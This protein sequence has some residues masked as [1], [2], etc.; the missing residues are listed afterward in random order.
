[1]SQNMNAP[2]IAVIISVYNGLDDLRM[3]LASLELQTFKNFEIVIAD[4]GSS[5]D[6]VKEMDSI[7]SSSPLVIRHIWHEDRG[8]RKNIIL[9]RA[10]VASRGQYLVFIDGDCILHPCLLH[11]HFDHREP[12]YLIAGRRVNL[13]PGITSRLD[14]QKVSGGVLW[15]KYMFRIIFGGLTGKTKHFEN[16]IYVKSPRLRNRIN[17]KEKHILGSHFSI[18]KEDI[19]AV[20]GFDERFTAPAAGEDT[21]LNLRLSRNGIRTKTLKHIAIQYHLY[22]QKLYRDPE[23]LKILEQNTKEN[24]NYTPYG[25]AREK[26][27]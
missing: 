8:W 4:D 15:G 2:E 21:D 20:N 26:T 12:G 19:L 7:I 22:H 10:I 11:E 9:N 14:P 25:I 5:E 24:I 16:A 13:S 18:H 23:R 27:D 3:V 6:V 1:M 17:K